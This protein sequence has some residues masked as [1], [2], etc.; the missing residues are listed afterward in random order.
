MFLIIN[1]LI[2]KD[3]FIENDKL[4]IEV[5]YTMVQKLIAIYLFVNRYFIV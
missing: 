3:K 1:D 2:P 4:K 5:Y